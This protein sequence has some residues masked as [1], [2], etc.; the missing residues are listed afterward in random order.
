[1]LILALSILA[2]ASDWG[3]YGGDPGGTRF[4]R[5]ASVNVR[6]V[7]GLKK[8]WEYHTGA[9]QP[10]TDANHRAAFECTPILV[11]G[12]LYV[13]T[14]FDQ[15]IALDP[16]TGAGKWKYDPHVDRHRD[17]SEVTSRGVAAWTD[18]KSRAGTACRTRLFEGTIDARL[19]AVDAES[20]RLCAAFGDHGQVDLTRNVRLQSPADYEVTS[21]PTV[22]GDV[23]V[24][25]SSIGDNRAFDVE[26]G[27]VRG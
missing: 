3:Y 9:L 1:M 15:I 23:V 7:A 19:I 8:A 17:Y 13:T 6:N 16:T 18:T 5:I 10:E 21:A 4:S 11:N 26:R 24:T 14:P 27:V 20:G 12:T 2:F 25:G 22:V